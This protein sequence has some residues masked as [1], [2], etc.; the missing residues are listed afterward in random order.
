MPIIRTMWSDIMSTTT[1][2][3]MRALTRVSRCSEFQL[4]FFEC[5]EAY[6]AR[7]YA[8][9]CKDFYNDYLECGRARKQEL[10]VEE[11]RR[12]RI[13]QVVRGERKPTEFWGKKIPAD[14]FQDGPFH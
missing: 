7:A 4:N 13:R 12:E 11:M 2:N 3:Q 5:L 6:G 9:K 10:Y 14:A 1:D 8:N